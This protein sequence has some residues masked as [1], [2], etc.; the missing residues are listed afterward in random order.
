[1]I[2]ALWGQQ[3]TT[4]Q[5]VLEAIIYESP[6]KTTELQKGWEDLL[7][8][9]ITGYLEGVGH[10]RHPDLIVHINKANGQSSGLI[11]QEAYNKSS[12]DQLLCVRMFLE[13]TTGSELIGNTIKVCA[14]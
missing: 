8:I 12:M 6:N 13:G 4:A 9:R 3:A 5:D 14:H 11:T 10:P 7:K 1:M 2:K